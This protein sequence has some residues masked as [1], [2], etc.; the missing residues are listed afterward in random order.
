MPSVIHWPGRAWHSVRTRACG[1]M[2][3][4]SVTTVSC[5]KLPPT[6][7]TESGVTVPMPEQAHLRVR[8]A[9]HDRRAGRQAGLGRRA[10]GDRS[11]DRARLQHR[12]HDLRGQADDGERSR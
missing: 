5:Q 10:A 6:S 9:D 3:G 12:R 1:S 11:D 4:W 2:S 8:A 7:V